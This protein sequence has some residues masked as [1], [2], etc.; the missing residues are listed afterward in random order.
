MGERVRWR[1]LDPALRAE[2]KRAGLL[3]GCGPKIRWVNW[4]VPDAVFGLHVE[5]DCDHHDFNYLLGHTEADRAKA[6]WQFFEEIRKR[7]LAKTESW[8]RRWL[9][10]VYRMAAWTYYRAVRAFGVSFFYYGPTERSREDLEAL[11]AEPDRA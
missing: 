4:L 8:W 9:R 3:N 10:P 7:A 11:I 1:D 2:M 6:D 5:E